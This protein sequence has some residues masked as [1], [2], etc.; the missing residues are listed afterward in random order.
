MS[1]TITK[2]GEFNFKGMQKRF[3]REIKISLPKIVANDTQKH[4]QSGFRSGGG[5]TNDSISGWKQR[6]FTKGKGSR[7]VLVNSGRL[8]K[9]I[10]KK[11]VSFSRIIIGTTS[12]TKDYAHTQNEGGN[13][14]I[15]K[16]MRS[17]FWAQHYKSRAKTEKE[18]WKNLALHKGNTI[19]IPKREFIGDSRV[20]E[21]RINMSVKKQME[22]VFK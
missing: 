2:K 13:I 6:Q 11:L 3:D 17:F 20:L 15:T 1:V 14:T 16:Q 7:G 5:K 22:K 9:D 19:K 8:R 12:L 21:R 4:F 18:Y 10:S